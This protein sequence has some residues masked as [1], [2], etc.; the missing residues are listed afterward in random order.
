MGAGRN[1]VDFSQLDASVVGTTFSFDGTYLKVE[2]M[3]TA[4]S[5]IRYKFKDMNDVIMGGTGS[6]FSLTN[7]A[8]I[9]GTEGFSINGG[10]PSLDTDIDLTSIGNASNMIVNLYDENVSD[11]VDA[12]IGLSFKKNHPTPPYYTRVHPYNLNRFGKLEEMEDT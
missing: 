6:T 9:G 3:A 5:E 4:G 8:E 10:D 7:L 1:T 11:S 2:N 12:N